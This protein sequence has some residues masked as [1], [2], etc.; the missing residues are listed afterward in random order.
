MV[1]LGLLSLSCETPEPIY[2]DVL[3]LTAVPV[4]EGDMAGT[5]AIKIVTTSVMDL[6]L[7]GVQESI[8]HFYALVQRTWHPEENLYRQTARACA[9]YNNEVAGLTTGVPHETYAKVPLSELEFVEVDHATGSFEHRNQVLLWG[10]HDLPDPLTTPLPK[11]VEEAEQSPHKEHIFDMDGD[12][13]PGV[14][15]FVSGLIEAELQSIQRK[16]SHLS[17]L[18]LGKDRVVGLLDAAKDTTVLAS[19]THVIETGDTPT[20]LHPDPKE[21]WFEEIRVD[22]DADCETVLQARDDGT[23]TKVRP[24]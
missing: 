18:T 22:D 1:G 20:P 2:D 11:T 19:S 23:L 7:V 15:F 6:P 10:L 3:D 5:F 14:P 17:G 4:E 13:K 16:I 9:G 12:E 21:S 24:F 8:S